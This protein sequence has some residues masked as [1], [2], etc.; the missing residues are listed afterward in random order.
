MAVNRPARI[1]IPRGLWIQT[2]CEHFAASPDT[3]ARRGSMMAKEVLINVGAGEIRVAVVENGVLD[4]L[5]LERSMG[6][7]ADRWRRRAAAAAGGGRSIMGDIVLGRVQR[8]IP[9]MQA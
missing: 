7:E 3:V 2:G 8:V 5:W 6:F 1:H 4:Q 9:A